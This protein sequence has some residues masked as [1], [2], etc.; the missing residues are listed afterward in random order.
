MYYAFYKVNKED[1]WHIKFIVEAYD[2]IMNLST[3][4]KEVCKIQ[5]SI[6]PDLKDDAEKILKDLETRFSM[7]RLDDDPYVTQGN[8]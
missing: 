5:I 8:Y 6:A 7:Q 2:N 1:V 4:D 3:I